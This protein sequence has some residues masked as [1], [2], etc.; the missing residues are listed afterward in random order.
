ME[1]TPDQQDA[2][3]FFSTAETW[4]EIP[5]RIDTPISAVFL[6]GDRAYKLKK[7]VTLPFL[8]YALLE[9]RQQFCQAELEIN[10]RASPDLYRAVRTVIR[11]PDGTLALSDEQ[12]SG[13]HILDYVVEMRRFAQ[14]DLLS[15]W[16]ENDKVDRSL[17][18]RL[19]DRVYALHQQAPHHPEQ[20][21]AANLE[22][23]VREAEECLR[24]H[25]SIVSPETVTTAMERWRD[26]LKRLSPLLRQRTEAGLV[27]WCHG[28]LHCN[29]VCLI[30]KEP[31]LFDAIE[32]APWIAC[33]DCLYDLAF[34]L[35]DLQFRGANAL[36]AYAMN[37]YFDLSGDYAGA[38]L[39]PLFQ[40]IRAGIRAHVTASL[41]AKTGDP[42]LKTTAQAYLDLALTL[43]APSAPQLLAVG[44][45]SGSGKSRMARELAPQLGHPAA[46]V[47]RSDA[48]R[49]QQAGVPLH[50]HLPPSSY[51]PE[52]SRRVYQT[53]Y[54]TCAALL[55]DGVCV[56]AD[57]VFAK[58]EER[59]AIAAVAVT[60]GVP[61]HG[62]WLTAPPDIAARR[63]RD[64]KPDASDATPDL[65]HR[66]QNYDLGVLTWPIID[67]SGPKDAVLAEGRK[68]AGL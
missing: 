58:P 50:E 51:T 2:I 63:I 21:S 40:S 67:S 65:R 66:Q 27:R 47:V 22:R 19:V 37:R 59:D 25:P 12:G 3:R 55:S 18:Y 41:A 6:V 11:R 1:T 64:R 20:D 53:L 28:D 43:L 29:N 33:T 60:T 45:V 57:A 36:A 61:F 46:V 62:L 39:L 34:L 23:I 30:D 4:G 13:G 8:D 68:Q 9:Q 10:R 52:S 42:A 38:V 5:Q 14:T 35:M 24:P 56:I 17:I 44:G 15:H 7:A 32:F 26:G 54:Q 16:V 31:Y 48:L 49:K